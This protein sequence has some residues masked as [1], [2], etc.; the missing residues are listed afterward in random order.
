[1]FMSGDQIVEAL[2]A[3]GEP[4]R[5]RILSLLAREEL[6]VMELSGI[7]QQ[8]QPRVSRHLK[9][10]TDSRLVDRFPDGARVFYRLSS[11]ADA[12]RLIDTILALLPD[13]EGAEDHRRLEAVRHERDAAA[14]AYF[15]RIA[16]QWDR[17]RSLHVSET[18]V[19]AAILQAAGP[20]PFERMIDLGTGSGRMLSL[21]AG[22]VQ[23]AVGL[24]L[25]HNM[26]NIARSNATRQGLNHVEL[27]HGDIFSTGLPD[28]CAD[29]VLVHQV[30]H[31]LVD[32]HAAVNEAARLVAPGGRL[33]I[34]DFAQHDLEQLRTDHQHRRLG[35]AAEEIADW[36]GEAGLT[37]L[38]VTALPPDNE[39]VT[40]SIWVAIQNTL[41]NRSAA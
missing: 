16:P 28:R 39:G 32:P 2:S 4:T 25:S 36:L 6:S 30:L 14:A 9:V 20:G 10:M 8:S 23:R 40:V 17:V 13:H 15:D 7:L 27:R 41:Q 19:E 24:D 5:L 12:R 34:V 29:L 31:Y 33:L 21:F 37:P 11:E 22:R 1:M 18:A 35:F 38:P 3:A 26:L